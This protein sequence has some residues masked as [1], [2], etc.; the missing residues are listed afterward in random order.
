MKKIVSIISCFIVMGMLAGCSLRQSPAA[1]PTAPTP[2]VDQLVPSASAAAVQPPAQQN[3]AVAQNGAAIKIRPD[4]QTINKG[5]KITVE[6]FIENVTGLAGADVQVQ[7]NPAVLQA[8]DIDPAKDGVQFQLGSF[9]KPDFVIADT[10]DNKTGLVQYALVQKAPT[11]PV[12]G[13]GVLASVSFEAIAD[14]VSDL[15]FVKTDLANGASGGAIVVTKVPGQVVVGNAQPA[16]PIANNPTA[17]PVPANPTATIA[18][19]EPTATFTPIIVNPP[20]D[21]PTLA[22]PANTSTPVVI[23]PP[24]VGP[25]EPL[26]TPVNPVTIVPAGAT[27]GYCYRVQYGDTLYSLGNRFG[28]T[29]D[30]ISL[31]NALWPPDHIYANQALFIPQQMGHGPNYHIV[32]QDETLASIAEQCHLPAEFIA[33]VNGL[34]QNVT[35]PIGHALRIPIP[36]FAPPARPPMARPYPNQRPAYAPCP[37]APSGCQT[38]TYPMGN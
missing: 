32:S 30:D 36:P 29:A 38:G 11:Q 9:V 34:P 2:Q 23:A 1:K 22:P 33:W 10:V 8:Q 37:P 3:V 12:D 6:I 20:T 28:T 18:P 13:S 19:N 16:T 5:Q 25:V 17:T 35:L 15:T 26:P 31:A 21:V 24:T 14:G 7:F 4:I 27:I